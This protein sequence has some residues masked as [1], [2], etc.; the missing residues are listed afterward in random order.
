MVI[1]CPRCSS[2]YKID[3]TGL[4]DEGTYA[5]CRKCENVFFVRKRSREEVS[6]LRKTIR[7]RKD[8]EATTF[9]GHETPRLPDSIIEA[10]EDSGPEEGQFLARPH[11]TD[12]PEEPALDTGGYEASEGDTQSAL[13]DYSPEPSEAGQTPNAMPVSSAVSVAAGNGSAKMEESPTTVTQDNEEPPINF[14]MDDIEALLAA[15]SPAKRTKA[16]VMDTPHPSPS[17]KKEE[18]SAISQDDIEA[19]MAANAPKPTAPKKEESSAISQDDIEALMAANAPKP[20][21]PKKEESSAISQ[22]DIEALMAANAPKPTAPNKEES[23]A[24]S[25]DDIEALMAANAPQSAKMTPAEKAAPSPPQEDVTIGFDQADIDSLLS[26]NAP[27]KK[28][29]QAPAIS[30][31]QDDIDA[32]LAANSPSAQSSIEAEPEGQNE[33]D[34]LLASAVGKPAPKPEATPPKADGEILSQSDLDALLGQSAQANEEGGSSDSGEDTGTIS[35]L[36]IDSILDAAGIAESER[37][38]EAPEGKAADDGLLSQDTL[39]S[40]LAEASQEETGAPTAQMSQAA[41]EPADDELERLLAGEEDSLGEALFEDGTK[42]APSSTGEPSLDEMLAG[43]L[44]PRKP[45][46]ASDDDHEHAGALQGVF[47][48]GDVSLPSMEED[49]G[50]EEAH[51]KKKGFNPLAIFAPVIAAFKKA[52]GIIPFHKFNFIGAIFHKLPPRFAGVMT[53]LAIAVVIGA[54]GGGW[55]F[56]KGGLAPDKTQVAMKDADHKPAAKPGDHTAAPAPGIPAATPATP[57]PAQAP[58]VAHVAPP[59]LAPSPSEV[60]AKAPT[61]GK[62]PVSFVVYLPVEFDA[63]TTKVLNMNVELQFESE[64]VAKLVRERLFFSAVTVEKAVDNFF[65]DKFYE[66]TVFAQ[67]KLE[68]FLAQNLKTVKQFAGLKDVRLS[69]FSID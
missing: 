54:I 63:E 56:F 30:A 62:F 17:P 23:S 37:G 50:D 29:A 36:E 3:A 51:A 35:E 55:W 66:E 57:A 11:S 25:Q 27:A 1:K 18:P 53:G 43:E 44:T 39:D 42:T 10:A 59:A 9:A 58:A 38:D 65:R 67:D 68:E 15:H 31:G 32:L 7:K 6:L 46:H 20:T 13:S 26:A 4:P 2:R 45:A 5:R 60:F 19:L 52:L 28:E 34:A 47:A 33:I 14:S 69:A 48:Q 22:D 40:L 49:A 61:N 12:E 24:I 16:D 21:A 64:T 8:A 41:D